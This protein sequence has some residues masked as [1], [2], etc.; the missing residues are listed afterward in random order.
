M[1]SLRQASQPKPANAS[2]SIS[3]VMAA[4]PK[5][6]ACPLPH[7]LVGGRHRD[8]RQVPNH[9]HDSARDRVEVERTPPVTAGSLSAGLAGRRVG[10]VAPTEGCTTSRPKERP[11]GCS[12]CPPRTASFSRELATAFA[13]RAHHR[14][15]RCACLHMGT[16]AS[17]YRLMPKHR[18]RRRGRGEAPPRARLLRPP[19][20]AGD[21][22]RAPARACR[23]RRDQRLRPGHARRRLARHRGRRRRA[24][25]SRCSRAS[26]APPP[27]AGLRRSARKIGP[28]PASID[29]AMIGGIAANNASGMCCGTAQNSYH[30]LAGL[31]VVLADGTVLDTRDAGQPRRVRARCGPS[32][33]R[34]SARWR[35]ATRAGRAARQPHPPQVPAQEHDRLQPERAD[36]LHATRSTSSRT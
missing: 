2:A 30:T 8:R 10:R 3:N 13:D 14:P 25:R 12:C 18:G 33:S 27:I 16:D 29:A 19:A 9:A 4:G 24:R 32:S 26:S 36:R 31:R 34:A 5:A 17:F 1:A 35:A 23:A 7:W 20:D 6:G 15:T 22:S 21:L 11:G 28:D